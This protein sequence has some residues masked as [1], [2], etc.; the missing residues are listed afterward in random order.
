MTTIGC[1]CSNC[2]N[3]FKIDLMI[4]DELWEKIKPPRGILC[5]KCIMEKI[6][7]I[8]DFDYWFLSKETRNVERR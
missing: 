5:G 6:E 4:P 3:L 1:K 2:L 8:S 7:R